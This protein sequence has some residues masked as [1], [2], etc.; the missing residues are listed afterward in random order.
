MLTGL[1]NISEL[2]LMSLSICLNDYKKFYALSINLNPVWW[3][4]QRACLSIKIPWWYKTRAG[5]GNRNPMWMIRANNFSRNKS[6]PKSRADVDHDSDTKT[7][8]IRV[9]VLDNSTENLVDPCDPIFW[10]PVLIDN[11]ITIPIET[12][13]HNRID[14]LIIPTA[15]STLLIWFYGG[16]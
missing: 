9:W 10:I 16:S 6:T 11:I 13:P 2:F 14:G 8:L 1:R 3:V 5:Y 7:T 15:L 12:L 4:E